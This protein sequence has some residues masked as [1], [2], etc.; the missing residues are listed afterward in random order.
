MLVICSRCGKGATV[1][2]GKP[3]ACTVCGRPV[4]PPR[5]SL[6]PGTEIS[7]YCIEAQIG[8]GG[9]GEVYRAWQVAMKRFVA[10]K[11]LPP[12]FR[13]D[14]ADLQH[15]LNEVKLAAKLDHPHIVTAYGAGEDSGVFYLAMEY[16]KGECLYDRLARETTIPEPEAL[17]IARAI[18]GALAYA[19]NRHHLVHGDVNPSNIIFDPAGQPKLMDMGLSRILRESGAEPGQTEIMGTPGYMSPEQARGRA[20]FDWRTDVY[21]LGATLYHM[22]TGHAPFEGASLMDTLRKQA[23]ESVPDPRIHEPGLSDACA[24]LL[25]TLLSPDPAGRPLSWEAVLEAID[26]TAAPPVPV[27][28]RRP[29]RRRSKGLRAIAAVAILVAAALGS[30]ALFRARRAPPPAHEE[31]R[32]A[33]TRPANPYTEEAAR[34]LTSAYPGLDLQLVLSTPGGGLAI[35]FS[36]NRAVN[37][38]PPLAHLPV[39]ELYL[40]GTRVADLAP[41]Q[42]M[43]LR[44]LDISYTTVGDLG[45][46]TGM[47]LE[48]LG[49]SMCSNIQYLT[50]LK[51]MPLTGL[52]AARTRVSNLSPLEGMPLRVL[53]LGETP[54][55]DLSPLKGMW[56]KSLSLA[57]TGVVDLRPLRDMPLSSLNLWNTG[58]DDLRP[59]AGMPLDTLDIAECRNVRDLSPLAGMSLRSLKMS[60]TAVDDLEPLRG[61]PLEEL[62]M[63]GCRKVQNFDVLRDMPLKVLYAED[64]RLSDLSVLVGAPI[65]VLDIS[66]TPATA[67]QAITALP[68]QELRIVDSPATALPA[69]SR[70]SLR[71]IDIG[72]SLI[73][74][75]E[76]LAG[77][78][79]LTWLTLARSSVTNLAPLRGLRL[80]FLNLWRTRVA[81]LGPLA[82]MPL[83][84]LDLAECAGVTDLS[85]L[86]GMPLEWLSLRECTGVTNLDVLAGMPLRHLD[87]VGCRRAADTRVVRSLLL[88]ESLQMDENRRDDAG[89]VR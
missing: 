37:V 89:G 79:T 86:R 8:K 87:I 2:A 75:V 48:F 45:P 55:T 30:A 36:H 25:S 71:S 51:G 56:L 11:V 57:R 47:R 46:L 85:P 27:R 23:T 50:P 21:S 69:L 29:R 44:I 10:L 64:T 12:G 35:N 62:R 68:L 16:V 31:T 19:W 5:H 49:I 63:N 24:G 17:A 74:S 13:K 14:P 83:R 38:I 66:R 28:V 73:S 77:L 32:P 52:T 82:G 40:Q 76:P 6:P 60:G 53:E 34:I 3:V 33:P 4:E 65:E 58:V 88:L 84:H 78:D 26:N 20:D 59:L 7:G 1:T 81:D 80:D 22:L 39:A 18:A 70:T 43:P 61:M 41:I 9:M 54:V 72:G 67:L 42:G 15:F